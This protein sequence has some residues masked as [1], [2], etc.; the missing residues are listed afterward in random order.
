MNRKVKIRRDVLN[1]EKR[2]SKNEIIKKGNNK[3]MKTRLDSW[4]DW[5]I[6]WMIK[7]KVRWKMREV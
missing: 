1:S 6:N 2:N 3:K 7:K 4:I 5:K